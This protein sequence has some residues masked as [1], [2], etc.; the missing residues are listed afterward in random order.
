VFAIP[1]RT[2]KRGK[3][4]APKK[5]NGGNEWTGPPTKDDVVNIDN[6]NHFG[7]NKETGIKLGLF[8]STG[9][10]LFSDI[11]PKCSRILTKSKK[12]FLQFED[13]SGPILRMLRETQRHFNINIFTWFK[14]SMKESTED[15]ALL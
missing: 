8:Q 6:A 14:F 13:F 3:R 4:G 9:F 2:K 5:R 11:N 15:I 1:A 7:S 10:E 12:G